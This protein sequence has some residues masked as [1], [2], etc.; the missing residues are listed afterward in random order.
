MELGNEYNKNWTFG[1]AYTTT[2]LQKS[3]SRYGDGT[4]GVGI[5][6]PNT[7]GVLRLVCA[8]SGDYDY[9]IK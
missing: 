8:C 6:E 3:C 4:I 2:P 5:G 1:F 9:P 7:D